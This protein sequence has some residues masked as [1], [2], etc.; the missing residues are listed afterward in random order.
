[1]TQTRRSHTATRPL[2]WANETAEPIP[3]SN[4]KNK[5]F[6]ILQFILFT[7]DFYFNVHWTHFN[8]KSLNQEV[9]NFSK[10]DKSA[11]FGCKISYFFT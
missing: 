6:F 2:V 3:I 11:D 10:I 7:N 9:F 1:M 8:L 5:S 4:T